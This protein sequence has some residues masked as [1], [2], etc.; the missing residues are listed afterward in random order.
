MR[1]LKLIQM[2]LRVMKLVKTR[3]VKEKE[4]EDLRAAKIA[5]GKVD[6]TGAGT[7]GIDTAQ[8]AKSRFLAKPEVPDAV[9]EIAPNDR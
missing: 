3:K 2:A 4:R 8:K 5:N 6:G 9:E 1:T 7:E